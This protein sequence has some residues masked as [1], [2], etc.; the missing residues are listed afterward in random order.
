MAP[1]ASSS[2]SFT[3]YTQDDIDIFLKDE[4]RLSTVSV[5]PAAFL[6][7][8][9]LQTL[10]DSSDWS[11]MVNRVTADET[12]LQLKRAW[13]GIRNKTD[14][15][16]PFRDWVEHLLQF[17]TELAP[18]PTR[19]IRFV[20]SND[21][22]L[23]RGPGYLNG[24][25]V[26][27]TATTFKPDVVC[28]DAGATEL[29]KWS[30]VLVPMEFKKGRSS[31]TASGSAVYQTTDSQTLAPPKTP[32]KSQ[33]R[34]ELKRSKEGGDGK[35]GPQGKEAE[36][37]TTYST[38]HFDSLATPSPRPE[39]YG[40]TMD[41]IR[42]ARYA[43]ETFAAVGDRTHVFALFVKRPNV[44]LWYFDHCGA[45]CASPINISTLEGFLLF[46]KFLSAL[47]YMRDDLLG[48]NPFFSNSSAT[49]PAG[50]R[51]TL[52][53][54][55]LTIP[56]S[57]NTTLTLQDVLDRRTGL[58]GRATLVCKA[59]LRKNRGEG[60][61]AREV[62]IKSSW[63]HST[64]TLEW[65]ILHK[66]H[67]DGR[68]RDH[69]VWCFRGWEQTEATVSSQRAK[70]GE[71]TPSVV[72]DRALR[73]T[74]L[75]YLNPITKLSKPF[76]ISFIGWNILQGMYDF[77]FSSL[78]FLL[79]AQAIK[80]LNSMRWFHCDISIG[81]MGYSVRPGCG[82]A[83]IKLHDFD[84]SKHHTQNSG[85]S[86]RTGTVPFMSIE[87]LEETSAP[88]MI[89]F[90]VEALT[91]TLLWI[92]RVCTDGEDHNPVKNHPLEDWYGNGNTLEQ[93]ANTKRSYLQKTRGFYTNEHYR[94]LE[95]EVRD[96]A[97][98]W[99]RMRRDQLKE[100][101]EQENGALLS[102]SVHGM[103]GFNTIQAWMEKKGWNKPQNACT[104]Q[105]HC[106]QE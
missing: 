26:E 32:P 74:V 76:H 90:E 5:T 92:V 103:T 36:I 102:E 7:F 64:R 101:D 53:G 98:L 42:L 99:D 15:Y 86:H 47:V 45:V 28:M 31:S 24:K 34:E 93:I 51:E 65:N 22:N 88:H 41:D 10:W 46:L 56:D 27:G 68:A 40:P 91:W 87:L 39:R 100:R 60:G 81:N 4:L 48:F 96:L 8:A 35:S 44:T 38:H 63:Q 84:L 55:T 75:E 19:Q 6:H 50:T 59:E 1:E 23:A 30:Q 73:H 72:D 58:V 71:P 97:R 70:F 25:E 79:L 20:P 69:I 43:M 11:E 3:F 54:L 82:G 104:C 13:D 67:R 17:I 105:K 61:Q 57:N 77:V 66:L 18:A 21:K 37:S 12:Q 94:D 2:H 95:P 106:R 80:F 83:V 85:T 14:Q 9:S 52:F 16:R 89:G 33:N 49:A 78:R 62:V 29:N